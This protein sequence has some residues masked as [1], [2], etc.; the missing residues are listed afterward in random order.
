MQSSDNVLEKESYINYLSEA[1]E[2]WLCKRVLEAYV[3]QEKNECLGVT[4]G[5]REKKNGMLERFR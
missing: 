3:D 4:A 5:G 2:L 1:I